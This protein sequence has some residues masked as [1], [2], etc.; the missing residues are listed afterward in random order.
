MALTPGQVQ[1]LARL[2]RR[3]TLYEAALVHRTTGQRVLLCY[4][5]TS[6]ARL[7]SYIAHHADEVV[8]FCGSDRYVARQAGEEYAIGDW[9]VRW[10]GRTQRE[11][12]IG[13][14]LPWFGRAT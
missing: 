11:A 4:S 9:G 8:A 6:G 10:T 2:R 3:D 7:G 14:E 5:H 13:G 1:K 12:I